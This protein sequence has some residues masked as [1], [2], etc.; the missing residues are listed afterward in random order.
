MSYSKDIPVPIAHTK[1]FRISQD[2]RGFY[3]FSFPLVSKSYKKE[4]NDSHIAEEHMVNGMFMVAVDGTPKSIR[5]I[6]ERCRTGEY[7][8]GASKI[9]NNEKGMYI[10]LTYSF[11]APETYK[12]DPEKIC[13]VDLGI[14]YAA[15]CAVNY[16]DYMRKGIPGEAILKHCMELERRRKDWSRAAT[17]NTSDGHGRRNIVEAPDAIRKK[18]SNY[19]VTVNRNIA[20]AVVS[21]ARKCGCGKIQMEDLRGFHQAHKDNRM[22]GKWTYF[23]LQEFIRQK[24]DYYGIEVVKVDPQNTSQTCSICGYTSKENRLSQAV[25]KC[26]RCGA[27]MNADFNAA[28]NIAMKRNNG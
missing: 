27:E 18:E 4:W 15:M 22:L 14:K 26:I 24:A 17:Y 25:F 21:F 3:Q 8:M 28:R 16:N 5:T 10:Y 6:L 19:H 23:Q 11:E 1:G 7:K 12:L 9:V 20:N 13:G 2:D